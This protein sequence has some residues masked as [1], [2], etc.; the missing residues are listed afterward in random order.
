MPTIH[1]SRSTVSLILIKYVT[2]PYQH[3]KHLDYPLLYPLHLSYVFVRLGDGHDEVA[4]ARDVCLVLAL[5]GT[6]VAVV[7][8][9]SHVHLQYQGFDGVNL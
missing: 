4:G 6:G 2:H 7:A 1:N 5:F 8:N 3:L 9:L